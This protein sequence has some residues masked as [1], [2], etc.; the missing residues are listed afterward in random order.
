MKLLK[1]ILLFILTILVI[2]LVNPSEIGAA[3]PRVGF[4]LSGSSGSESSNI[5]IEIVLSESSSANVTVGFEVAG[6]TATGEGK[7]YTLSNGTITFAPGEI[8]K[9]INADIIDDEI[10]EED[11]T[12]IIILLTPINATLGEIVSHTYT[13]TDND[14]SS[15]AFT[16]SSSSDHEAISPANM[17]VKLSVPSDRKITVNYKLSG[18]ATGNGKDY[19]LSDGALTFLAGETSKKISAEITN[20]DLDEEDETLV[21]TLSDPVNATLGEQTSHTYTITDNDTSSVVFK[22]FTSNGVEAVSP[23]KMDVKLSVPSDRT[24][25]VKYTASGTAQGSGV[26][27]TIAGDTLTFKPGETGKTIFVDIHDD[28]EFETDETII[29]MLSEVTNAKLGRVD[30]F[31]YWILNDDGQSENISLFRQEIDSRDEDELT[32]L[33]VIGPK[34]QTVN[35]RGIAVDKAGN[36]Y[37]SDQGPSKGKKEGSILMW[38]T[39]KDNVIRI[40]TGLTQPGDV[41]LSPDQKKLIIAGPKGEVFRYALGISIRIT[42]VEA[43]TG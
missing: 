12:L 17:E 38:P 16:V 4:A 28:A 36:L 33:F 21:L 29:V 14:T 13:I 39:G 42:N 37:I 27:Y 30:G 43:F 5:V 40:I 24:I 20:D 32:K 25:T 6:G 1:S 22:T 23:V 8:R 19:S 34:T 11:E 26:D 10:D 31:T 18:T 3:A 41:E 9:A 35:P 7:D 15:V 2:A